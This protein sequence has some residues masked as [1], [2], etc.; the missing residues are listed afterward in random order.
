MERPG[1]TARYRGALLELEQAARA[2]VRAKVKN[3]KVSRTAPCD[4]HLVVVI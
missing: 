2:E 1:F 4:K 3:P